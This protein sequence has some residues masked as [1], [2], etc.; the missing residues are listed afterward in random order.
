MNKKLENKIT[1]N[2]EFQNIVNDLIENKTVQEMKNYRQHFSTSCFEHCYAASYYCYRICKLLKL[3]YKSAARGAMLHDLFLYDWREKGNR[4]GFHAF[5]HGKTA[6]ENASKLFDL[7]K[8]EKDMI[9]KHMWPVTIS[10]PRYLETL[11]LTFVDKYCAIQE[12]FEDLFEDFSI[13]KM[14]K[15]SYVFLALIIFKKK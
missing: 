4:S 11:I 12:S 8:I 7:N 10:F 15:Y 9:I 1:K 5:T 6:Y 14:F 2:I 13:R 3:D